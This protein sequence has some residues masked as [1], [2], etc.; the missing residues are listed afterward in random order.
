MYTQ[1]NVYARKISSGTLLAILFISALIFL[2]P[3]TSV[4]RGS[5]GTATLAGVEESGG[6]VSGITLSTVNES[7]Y[8]GTETIHAIDGLSP[9]LD[10]VF[11]V[12]FNNVV[13]NGAQFRFY[14]STDGYSQINTTAGETSDIPYGP[15]F[16]V[17]NFTANCA[18]ACLAVN[19]TG[20]IPG[21]G[22]TTFYQGSYGGD[23]IVIG[24]IPIRISAEYK[25]IKIYDG[26]STAV[27]VAAEYIAVLPGIA[28]DPT[29]GAPG[30]SV[31]V[32]GGGFPS[33]VGIG[34]NYTYDYWSW[35]NVETTV[36][37]TWVSSGITNNGGWFSY[38]TN[39]IDAKQAVTPPGHG[40]NLYTTAI[41][42]IAVNA[43]KLSQA[44]TSGAGNAVFTEWNRVIQQVYSHF[45]S[46][47][48]IDTYLTG[49]GNESGYT[50]APPEIDVYVTGTLG[51]EGNF[52]YAGGSVTVTLGSSSKTVTSNSLSGHFIAN[53]TVP[54]LPVG[55]ANVTVTSNGV[56]YR[57]LVYVEPTFVLTP[58]QGPDSGCNGICTTSGTTVTVAAYGFPADKTI[59]VYWAYIKYGDGLAYNLVNATTNAD[60][61]FTGTITFQVP[62]PTYGGIHY[63]I[64]VSNGTTSYL[65]MNDS[66]GTVYEDESA[67][68]DFTVTPSLVATPFTVN[69]NQPGFINVAVEGLSPGTTY[70]IQIDHSLYGY[71]GGLC[72]DGYN[73]NG[74]FNFTSS[75]TPGLHQV[76]ITPDIYS[77][78]NYSTP[79]AWTY[80]NVT[81]TGDYI[82]NEINGIS[83]SVTNSVNNALASWTT[84]LDNIQSAVTTNIPTD[85]TNAQ[86]SL[87][88]DITN[89]QT[90]IAGDITNAQT[91][92][93]N[94]ISSAQTSLSSQISAL[95]STA[96]T[97]SSEATQAANNSSAASSGASTAQTYVLVV[98][99][100]AAITLVLELAILVRK[101][102]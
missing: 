73:G 100:L 16:Y 87:A 31:S 89:A 63:I 67:V 99:V 53:V 43:S 10:D 98:A 33:T 72:T 8:A 66:E 25:W 34:L 3:A 97:A 19:G 56:T 55:A 11:A 46:T 61:S 58:Y 38:T 6:V 70:L 78:Y 79:A 28:L 59:W 82:S 26:T 44:L 65:G 93:T 102:S 75:F 101:L 64:A 30:I 37:G 86:T 5:T 9:G 47:T 24:V 71:I 22:Q 84:T 88:T 85:I 62:D 94:A 2:L 50:T 92:I 21:I 17:Q 96:N 91:A 35:A 76:E 27:A 90:A 74:Q 54:D 49:W 36:V 77:Y 18:T 68:A 60:G 45:Q 95:Q 32:S 1:S 83:S 12:E 15:T 20:T 4:V 41:T 23:K 48:N 13:F 40:S 51:V 69:S 42:I 29:S 81:T 80:F 57:F 39:I 52:T 14:I 7:V